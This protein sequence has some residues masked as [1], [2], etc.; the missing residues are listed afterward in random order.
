[1]TLPT[2]KIGPV[3]V[4]RLVSG[5]NPFSGYSHI[6]DAVSREMV[7]W[8]TPERIK[9]VLNEAAEAGIQTLVALADDHIMGVLRQYWQEGGLLRDWI[10][11]V[12]KPPQEVEQNIRDVIALGA[13]AAFIQGGWVDRFYGQDDLGIVRPWLEQIRAAGLP[14]GLAA[15]RPEVHPAAERMK[16]PTDFYMQCCYNLTAHPGQY[17]PEDRDK[18]VETIQ[19]LDK[20]CIAYKIM[21][22]GRNDPV[23]AFRFAF[24]HIKPTDAVCV[25]FF[26]KRRPNE[27]SQDAGLAKLHGA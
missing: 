4:T 12:D 26:P 14:A 24:Q 1:M 9:R 16:L 21:A 8:Y 2:V 18:A 7:E 6:S 13:K 19:S 25:G 20:P 22:A 27:I 17:L 11:Q 5:A 3:D 15:H 10:A 23:E